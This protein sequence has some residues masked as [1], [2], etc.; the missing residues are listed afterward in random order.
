MSETSSNPPIT[1]PVSPY[2]SLNSRKL[3]E[4][5]ERAL[6]HYLAPAHIMATP[7]TPSSMFLVNHVK[8]RHPGRAAVFF[9]SGGLR[10]RWWRWTC[11]P[12]STSSA[13]TN[14]GR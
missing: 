2:E 13:S 7:Y 9:F 3:H 5:A 12:A 1:D 10:P 4:A 8:N 14:A 11:P 6:D